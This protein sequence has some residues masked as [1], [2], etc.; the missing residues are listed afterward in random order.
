[1]KKSDIFL[2]K[3]ETRCNKVKQ[4]KTKAKDRPLRLR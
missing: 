4:D 2:N 1:M 3:F